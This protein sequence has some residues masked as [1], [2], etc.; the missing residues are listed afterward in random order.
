MEQPERIAPKISNRARARSRLERV[1]PFVADATEAA[2]LAPSPGDTELDALD[3][4]QGAVVATLAGAGPATGVIDGVELR[5]RWEQQPFS[6]YEPEVTR[7]FIVNP[8]A[9]VWQY[10][11][12]PSLAY[13]GGKWFAQWNANTDQNEGVVGQV[14]LQATSEDFVTWTSPV[15]VF[16]SSSTSVPV[17]FDAEDNLQWQP[18]LVV[19]GSELWS[20][21][22]Q[23]QKSG[24]TYPEGWAIY[25]SRLAT[26][27]G[28]WTSTK[29]ELNYEEDG[30]TYYG[31]P[32]QNPI[33]LRSGRVLVP[34]SWVSTD[35]VDPLP[36][37][38]AT[39][40]A[41]WTQRKRAGVIYSDDNGSTWKIGGATTLPGA[42]HTAWEPVV[43]E[44]DDGSLRIFVRNLDYKN[45]TSSQ[46]VTTAFGSGEGEFFG[47]LETLSMDCP[48]TRL[49][50][51]FQESAG[52]GRH[53][54]LLNDWKS[55]G[56]VADR[57]NGAVF[58]SRSG[59]ANLTPGVPFSGEDTVVSYPQGVI[60]DGKLHIIYSQGV[61]PRGMKTA[62]VDPAPDVDTYYFHP[63]ENDQINPRASYVAGPPAY[64]GHTNQSAMLSTENTSG[65]TDLRASVGAWVYRTATGGTE[66]V[67]D[68]R[69]LTTRRGFSFGLLSG[70][71]HVT[72]FAGA[73][74]QFSFPSLTVPVGE[75]VY[76]G[77]TIDPGIG[78][79]TCYVVKQDGS[80]ASGSSALATHD[81]FDGAA[82]SIGKASA[83]SSLQ[84]FVGRIRR[85]SIATGLAATQ[86][87][88]RFWHGRD[89]AA[90][91]VI[92]WSGAET[93]PGVVEGLD[94]W[95]G[96]PDAGQNN[97]AWLT[98][99][100][101]TG[102][103]PGGQA[104]VT[105]YEGLEVL[106][107]S[108]TGSAGVETPNVGPGEEV[109]LTTRV[110][111]TGKSAGSDQV[112]FTLGGRSGNVQVLSRD[113]N[114][115][116]VEV[117]NTSSG[118]YTE[119]GAFL[120]E[121]VPIRI[122]ISGG[123]VRVSYGSGPEVRE[124]CLE[125]DPVVFLGLGYL[126]T[127]TT[128]PEDTFYV[129]LS[130]AGFHVHDATDISRDLTVRAP[131]VVVSGTSPTVVV[132]GTSPTIVVEGTSP[133]IT[134]EDPGVGSTSEVSLVG[135]TLNLGLPSS[136]FSASVS[137]VITWAVD[138]TTGETS[139]RT[140]G[141]SP[142][143]QITSAV[144]APIFIGLCGEGTFNNMTPPVNNRV[145]A[146]FYG[147]GFYDTNLAHSASGG[148]RVV[149]AQT[150]TST[151]KGANVEIETT[152]V[153]STTRAVTHRFLGTGN[154]E[155][156]GTSLTLAGKSV[157]TTDWVQRGA[158][159]PEGVVTA[160]VGVLFLRTDGGAG[161]TLYVKESGSGNT[162]WVAK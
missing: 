37:G 134:L 113:A 122:T 159:S 160:S 152:P 111:S 91:G 141:T 78:G 20:F 140:A 30:N 103:N 156:T 92:D 40:T 98:E 51:L 41:F 158:G 131:A 67:V 125:Q 123:S 143:Y 74:E 34:V 115:D 50:H 88:H 120:E 25:F 79:V 154:A 146:A 71:P 104:V 129:D 85:V 48:S 97:E 24:F 132:E 87:N 26:P 147:S 101:A 19:V 2:S 112:F 65:W 102:N 44:N 49:G 161:T 149:A 9:S 1:L 151:A 119:L 95:A 36:A 63:R 54:Y 107:L 55:G 58:I 28:K 4:L 126:G 117:Y 136:G 5:A 81:G 89:Q 106:S 15:A 61:A 94:Y 96:D 105:T 84:P 69:N 11:H 99:W 118:V 57:Y 108:G 43:Q 82:A 22:M 80:V 53:V 157:V 148:L 86:E 32:T 153:G 6:V 12:D 76:L 73:T 137:G 7:R 10:N 90:L 68:T 155:F 35:H 17:E 31:F 14:N 18:N 33:Q 46:Y 39:P 45:Y 135:N 128:T 121:W 27:N 139:V 142:R 70:Y 13:F 109:I 110:K 3:K 162:G 133:S 23:E 59:R 62:L 42:E 60:R 66:V 8:A 116:K 144:F 29:L 47:P 75:W 21:W 150:F 77:V 52:W 64:F 56:F 127:R 124:E 16:N 83:G 100:G 93:N 138:P 145:L 38:W 130:S 114:P 72:L